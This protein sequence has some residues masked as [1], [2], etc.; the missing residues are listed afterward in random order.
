MISGL[1]MLVI[2]DA[3]D[4]AEK[5]GKDLLRAGYDISLQWTQNETALRNALSERDYDIVLCDDKTANIDI[6]T[7]RS[8]IG[9]S[10]NDIPFIGHL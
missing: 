10:G 3:A 2:C 5:L 7:A 8:L 4:D 1:R 6:V 9:E